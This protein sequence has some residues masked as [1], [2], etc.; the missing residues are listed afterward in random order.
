MLA[1]MTPLGA[2]ARG[3]LAGAVGTLAMDSVWYARYRRGG[4]TKAPLAWELGLDVEKWED[5]PAPAQLGRRLFEAF[6]QRDLPVEKAALVNDVMHWSYGLAS[7]A[8]FGAVAG[9]LRT[10]SR[11]AVTALG[12]PFGAAVWGLSYATLPLAGL[13]KPIWEYDIPVLAKDLSAHLAYG[14]GTAGVFAMLAPGD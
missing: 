11:L 13:Y 4:G 1:G 10:R 2:L 7:G 5:A 14:V 9:S 12:L 8:A 6:T 3:A